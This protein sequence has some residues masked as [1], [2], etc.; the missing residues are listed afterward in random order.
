MMIELQTD[1]DVKSQA[2]AAGFAT[3]EDYLMTLLDRDA[4][5]IAI[6]AGLDDIAAGRMHPWEEVNAEIRREF[7][8]DPRT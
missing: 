8:F 4:E 6:Q 2:I 5:R 3:V 1:R 7:G